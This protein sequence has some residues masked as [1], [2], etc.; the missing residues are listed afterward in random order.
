MDNKPR[1]T[2]HEQ[3]KNAVRELLFKKPGKSSIPDDYE[4]TQEELEEVFKVPSEQDKIN[5]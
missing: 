3:F 4:P 2:T 5:G 1:T